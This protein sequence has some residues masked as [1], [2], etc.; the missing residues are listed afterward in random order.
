MACLQPRPSRGTCAALGR[1][2]PWGA[3]VPPPLESTMP[4]LRRV[5]D[6]VPSWRETVS[7][8]DTSRRGEAPSEN[9]SSSAAASAVAGAARAGV[10]AAPRPPPSPS[11]SSE[12]RPT[13]KLG[14]PRA[15]CPMA[16]PGRP[17]LPDCSEVSPAAANSDGSTG[18]ASGVRGS[19]PP[20]RV[21]T[22]TVTGGLPGGCV[23]RDAGALRP[24]GTATAGCAPTLFSC[25]WGWCCGSRADAARG[26]PGCAVAFATLATSPPSA[27]RR[28]AVTRGMVA[29]CGVVAGAAVSPPPRSRAPAE[30]S[31]A[32]RR[33]GPA[34]VPPSARLPLALEPAACAAS[35]ARAASR[36]AIPAAYASMRARNAGGGPPG[37]RPGRTDVLTSICRAVWAG[38]WRVCGDVWVVGEGWGWTK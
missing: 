5:C 13:R 3:S 20:R 24:R 14:R 6:D 28:P 8:A 11:R 2:L 22:T 15:R 30:C 38:T 27:A 26:T 21:A 9:P 1:G 4:P 33:G 35:A 25:H 29:T 32:T 34:V 37:R 16:A 10:T 17:S 23:V 12:G 19:A 7:D 36:A 31:R 18:T